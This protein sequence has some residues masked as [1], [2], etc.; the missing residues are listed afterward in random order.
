MGDRSAE[1]DGGVLDVS[2][3]DFEFLARSKNPIIHRA[4]QRLLAEAARL[5]DVVAR[6]NSSI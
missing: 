2:D 6:F 3:A 1:A 5:D 4:A